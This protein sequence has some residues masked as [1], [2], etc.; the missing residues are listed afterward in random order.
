MKDRGDSHWIQGQSGIRTGHRRE[1]AMYYDQRPPYPGTMDEDLRYP[2]PGEAGPFSSPFF[3]PTTHITLTVDQTHQSSLPLAWKPLTPSGLPMASADRDRL[4]DICDE[5]FDLLNEPFS[6]RE[7]KRIKGQLLRRRMMRRR[8]SRGS[9]T[10]PPSKFSLAT[11]LIS[12]NPL[13]LSPLSLFS[14][15]S[16]LSPVSLLLSLSSFYRYTAIEPPWT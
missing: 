11:T 12:F 6:E 5:L 1:S 13:S 7:E 14:P 3:K 4:V 16:S 8:R 10:S 15:P 2:K 9:T